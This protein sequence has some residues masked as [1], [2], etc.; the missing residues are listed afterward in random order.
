MHHLHALVM[1]G[2]SG[3]RF[4]PA[5]R[6]AR[7][8]Q[9]LPIAP[10][11][12]ESLLEATLRRIRPLCPEERTLIVTG[13]HLLEATKHAVRAFPGVR[14]VGEPMARN[15]APC[16][17][18][19]TGLIRRR[20][21]EAIV[22]A[23][24]SDHHVQDPAAFVEAAARAA[25]SAAEGPITTL[26]ITPT[27]PETGYG[28][29]EASDEVAAGVRKAVRFV[30]KPDRLRA[31]EYARSGRH[32][33]NSGLFFFRASAMLEAIR[34]HV[35]D[36]SSGLDR[37]DA[38][39][40]KGP[41]VEAEETIA[42]F[43]SMPNV[44]IDYAVMEKV[45]PVHVVPAECGW[46]DLGSWAASWELANRDANDNVV[47]AE[48]V[49]VDAE[50]NL[51]RDLSSGRAGKVIALVGVSGL[52][53]IETDDALLVMPVERAQDVRKVVVELERRGRKETL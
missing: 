14:V 35:P 42:A 47:D 16:I 17:G 41:D 19:G 34:T 1:A 13:E 39:C 21:P 49:L 9:L 31:E 25:K 23:L 8:K 37:I 27:G 11:T 22:M 33:W 26:G 12:A 43:R 24:P 51:V 5:S 7:P 28:Y 50:R 29:I 40:R 4:W 30:E 18:W 48:A 45:S 6:R 32:F 52:A 2:G 44:S 46:S 36:L 53:V 15:T 38:A 3:T 10:G 20:D